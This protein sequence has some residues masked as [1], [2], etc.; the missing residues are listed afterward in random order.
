MR[1]TP[2]R[3]SIQ[4]PA[5]V[6]GFCIAVISSFIGLICGA[7][8]WFFRDGMGPGS[9]ESSGFEALRRFALDIWPVGIV[10]IV[11]FAIAFMLMRRP[12]IVRNDY[13]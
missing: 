13:T 3:A 2:D 10:C 9:I 7:I 4:N 6:I 5:R 8:S 11:L 1:R 12:D